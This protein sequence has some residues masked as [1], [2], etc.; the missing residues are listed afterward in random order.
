VTE[1]IVRGRQLLG[2]D[3][4]LEL[5]L[6]GGLRERVETVTTTAAEPAQGTIRVQPGDRRR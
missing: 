4:P 3:E 5:R 2:I 1:T 6:I